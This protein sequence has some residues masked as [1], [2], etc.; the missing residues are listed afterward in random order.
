MANKND[1]SEQGCAAVT[2]C[3][4]GCGFF[5]MFE[6]KYGFLHT[7]FYSCVIEAM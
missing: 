5:G 2:L 3:T 4:G 1:K 6:I 7:M